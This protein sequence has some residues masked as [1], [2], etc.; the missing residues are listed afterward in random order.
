[1]DSRPNLLDEIL[2]VLNSIRMAS[3]SFPLSH[4]HELVM[5]GEIQVA[6]ENL[7][8]NLFE[9]DVEL[10]EQTRAALVQACKSASVSERYWEDFNPDRP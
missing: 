9:L 6:L 1:M 10:P 2:S 7:C 4:V 3:P 8:D 5:V